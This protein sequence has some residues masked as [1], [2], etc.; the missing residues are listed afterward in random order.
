MLVVF[1]GAIGG[2]LVSGFV[3]LFTGAVILSLAYIIFQSW[4]A[5]TP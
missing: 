3:G 5:D 2:F 1:L 4:L